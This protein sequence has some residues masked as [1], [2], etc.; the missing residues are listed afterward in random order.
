MSIETVPNELRNLRACMICGLIKTFTQFEV[1][2]CDNCEDFLSLKDNKD[3]VY[4][5]TSANFDGMIGLMSPDDSWVARWQRISKF[6]KGI[7][8]VSVSGTLP[9]HVQRMLS[10]RGVPYRSLDLSIDPASSNKR[11]RIEYTAEPD[12]SA[13]SA[14]FIVYS[15]ADLL[16]SNSDSDNVPESEKQLLPNLLEQG[17]LARQHLLRY[18]P[19]NV[20]SR[21]LNKEISAYFNPSRFATRRV[22]ANNVDGL[23]APFNP[24]GFHFGKA[25][26]TEIT[27]KLW[28]EAW[29]S[30]P[31][32]RVQ[33]FVN[34]SPIDRQHYVIVPDC[35]LQL[36]QCLT[37]F[38][39]MSGLHLLLLTPGTR[40][41]LGFNSLLAYASVNHLHL[42]LWRSE[43]VCL[44]TGCEI[45][46][47]DSDIG[48][49]TF[50]LD[51]MPVRTMVFELDS[52]EQDSVNLL[53][54]RVMSAVVACQ[55]ANVPHNLIAG[56]TLSDSDD[57]CGRLRVC[58]FPRQPARYC[59]D[60]AY[61]VAVAE[62]S[63]QLIVQDAD[64]FDQLT[65]AD[66]LAS[67]AK[68]SVSE[69]QFEDLRQSYRQILKQQSQCQS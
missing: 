49:Y 68:C 3:M 37:P 44:A 34:I 6:Q 55:R 58:L 16:I 50:P 24:S 10:E 69:D 21:Q 12:N 42:H 7:Y 46:P 67:Y 51:R 20:K 14:P 35:E 52:G 25:D 39:L 30:K 56:R 40:Y 38:A 48:L 41:R 4:D 54:S 13:L 66:V 31:L 64:T 11:M 15:D 45:V 47:L 65:V 8:A 36:N 61:C 63:G 27:V 59:P 19:D 5:C 43:P 2:G 18:Q 62:L 32:P 33:L 23:N 57:S 17:W 1:D 53:H 9:R 60:S 22:H 28:H 29:G 26:R